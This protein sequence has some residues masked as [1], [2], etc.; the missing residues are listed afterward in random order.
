MEGLPALGVEDGAKV[1]YTVWFS[2]VYLRTGTGWRNVFGQ[3]SLPLPRK[4]RKA[5]QPPGGRQAA[6]DVLPSPTSYSLLTNPLAYAVVR[7]WCSRMSCGSDPNSGMPSP[8][9]TGTRVTV[10]R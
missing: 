6:T 8:I 5:N 3:A 1:D 7:T 10:R 4:A 9:N 2:D